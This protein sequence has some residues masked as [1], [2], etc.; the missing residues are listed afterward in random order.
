[1][2]HWQIQ[3]DIPAPVNRSFG[4]TSRRQLTLASQPERRFAL[5]VLA[6]LIRSGIFSVIAGNGLLS[7][8]RRQLLA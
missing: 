4:T 5:G 8:N 2:L 7:T 6:L 3:V 1:V